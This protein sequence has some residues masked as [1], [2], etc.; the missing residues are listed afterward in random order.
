[1]FD[2]AFW[3]KHVTGIILADFM[4]YE[5]FYYMIVSEQDLII[6]KKIEN[7]STWS[8]HPPIAIFS[9]AY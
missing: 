4:A 5:Q 9:I 3:W 8:I 1:M 2:C 6:F 7:I